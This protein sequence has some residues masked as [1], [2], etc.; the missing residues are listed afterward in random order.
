MANIITKEFKAKGMHCTSC[1]KLVKSSVKEIEGVKEIKID[2]TTEK[3]EVTFDKEKTTIEE[4]FKSIEEQGYTCSL[5][6][7]NQTEKDSEYLNINKNLIGIIFGIIGILLIG[8]FIFNL[9]DKIALPS[10]SSG[11]GYGLLFLV[12]ILTGFHCVAMCGGFVVG[13][14]AKDAQEGRKSYRSHLMYAT[15][16]IISYTLIGAAFGLLGSII[17]FTPFMRGFAGI[18]AGIFLILFGINMLFPFLRKIRLKM[19]NSLNKFVSNTSKKNNS[20]LIIGLLNGLMIACGPLQAIYI[21]AAGTGI[22]ANSL[23]DSA[24]SNNK[25][26]GNAID[27]GGGYQTIR[28]DVT[29][30]GWEPNKFVLKKGVPVKWIINGKEINGC[31]SA[32]VVPKLGLNFDIKPGEQTIE[33][34]PKEESNIPW[35]CWMGMIQGTFIVKDD[36]D[37]NDKEQVQKELNSVDV[38]KSSSCGCGGGR[39]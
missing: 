35:S 33:F 8:Y 32:I 10:I 19:P 22:D 18:I 3:G 30:R 17:A 38:P 26:I 24:T 28:M 1:E 34:T 16:K 36:I 31:N 6:E 25:I 12:G 15:G 27:V 2:Y 13:Y 29:N 5:I 4:I 14:T 37:P 11:M 7:K 9:T 20:P 23:L 21:M 39:L